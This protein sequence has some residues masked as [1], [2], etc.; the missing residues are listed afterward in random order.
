MKNNLVPLNIIFDIF[1]RLYKA[2]C[3]YCI[4]SSLSYIL[5][6]VPDPRAEYVDLQMNDDIKGNSQMS[7]YFCGH[8]L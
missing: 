7:M 6:T 5:L 3:S 4:Y 2:C 8:Y 1:I